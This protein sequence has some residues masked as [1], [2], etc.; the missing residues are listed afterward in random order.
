MRF[1]LRR[2]QTA[3]A[4][5]QSVLL[6]AVLMVHVVTPAVTCSEHFWTSPVASHHRHSEATSHDH[7][8]VAHA[9]ND[10][11][12][13]R[14]PDDRAAAL[15]M[16]RETLLG[17]AALPTTAATTIGLLVPPSTT[18]PEA[19]TVRPGAPPPRAA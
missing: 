18:A 8:L 12:Q 11:C 17:V 6:L 16:L 10:E 9:E 13:L 7:D 2:R 15:G 1:S 14:A 3:T 5:L 19:V 4:L